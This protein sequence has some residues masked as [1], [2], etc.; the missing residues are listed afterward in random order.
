VKIDL[1]GD[2]RWARVEVEGDTM[3]VMRRAPA[4]SATLGAFESELVRFEDASAAIAAAEAKL[5]A[6]GVEGYARVDGLS[7]YRAETLLRVDVRAEFTGE[8]PARY[9]RGEEVAVVGVDGDV[10]LLRVTGP[11]GARAKAEEC[12]WGDGAV[13]LAGA[14][15]DGLVDEGFTPDGGAIDW[16]AVM[17]RAFGTVPKALR[18]WFEEER[19]LAFEGRVW[20]AP[21]SYVKGTKLG[22]T[23]DPR[24]VAA[25][26]A[27]ATKTHYPIA[28]LGDEEPM[29]LAV[30]KRDKDLKVTLVGRDGE[31][32][33]TG[34][35][36]EAFAARLLPT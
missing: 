11:R 31:T 36:L 32:H 22:V 34:I 16:V 3:V 21:P 10:A 15:G 35:G 19:F 30:K 28:A 7:T 5:A 33:D 13:D 24:R 29:W 6:L 12:G 23:F 25:S 26:T 17:T 9:T 1:L 27:E 4:E 20:V 18:P 14:W 8:A 2:E